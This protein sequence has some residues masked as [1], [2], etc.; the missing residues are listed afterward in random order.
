MTVGIVLVSGTFAA[1]LLW[2]TLS[3]VGRLGDLAL[4]LGAIVRVLEAAYRVDETSLE[5]RFRDLEDLVDRLPQRWEE[6][7]REASRLDARAR[8]AVGR[9]REELEA[10][11][12]ADERL[13][14]LDRELRVV[15]GSGSGEGGVQPLRQTVESV[16][17]QDPQPEQ[18]RPEWEQ[19]AL[20]RKF[21]A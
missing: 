13:D 14:D 20:A 9:T 1:V 3:A 19:R 11:G 12:L 7:K 18:P 8:Y 6:I 2:A 17:R 10:R 21:G 5:Q 16:P 4:G 15:D